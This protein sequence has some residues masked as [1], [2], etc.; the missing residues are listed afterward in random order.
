LAEG[1]D[2][3]RRQALLVALRNGSIIHRRHLNL[4][5]EYDLS[6]E[7][8]RDSVGLDLSKILALDVP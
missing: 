1:P 5:G 3:E 7:R 4:H 6:E 2:A 8:P